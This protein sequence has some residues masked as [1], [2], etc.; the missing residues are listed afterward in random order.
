[1][2]II[3]ED[4]G[5]QDQTAIIGRSYAEKDRRIRYFCQE[6]QGVS[7]VRNLGI[8]QALGKYV[9]F[10]DSDDWVDPD[11]ISILYSNMT[12]GG[13]A[14]CNLT[15]YNDR[16]DEKWLKKLSVKQVHIFILVHQGMVRFPVNKIFYLE[17]I[18]KYHISFY[19]DI[20][21]HYLQIFNVI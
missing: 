13:L 6:N 21:Y 2:D 9:C 14:A 17:I 15:M 5:S 16:K 3:L 7:A 1:M 4:D 20:T 19:E 8:Q 18:R 12:E 11:Y 10:V